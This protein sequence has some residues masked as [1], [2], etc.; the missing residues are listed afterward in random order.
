M[1]DIIFNVD[2][3]NCEPPVVGNTYRHITQYRLNWVTKGDE[4]ESLGINVSIKLFFT[5][6][7]WGEQEYTDS[8]IPFNAVDFSL[9][10]GFD[11]TSFRLEFTVDNGETCSY[12]ID[13]PYSSIIIT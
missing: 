8:P 9:E 13:I 5:A 6:D 11:E 7:G 2:K 4:Y 3:F 12:S 10:N 1:G